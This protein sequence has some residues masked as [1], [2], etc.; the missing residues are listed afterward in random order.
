MATRRRTA[1]AR[2]ATPR[3]TRA[4]RANSWSSRITPEVVRSIIGLSLMVLGAMTFIALILPGQGALTSWWRDSF[5]PWFGTMRWLL[6]FFLLVAGWWLEWG[7]G[8]R[9]GSGWGITLL[10]LGITYAGIV[11][12]MQVLGLFGRAGDLI[13]LFEYPDAHPHVA[14]GH[15][16]CSIAF[17]LPIIASTRARTCSFF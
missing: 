1:A 9:P 3:S 16:L 17:S 7:P 8:T 14:I 15:A 5:A 13:F 11:A 6:P 12:A 2:K 4:R 10:G